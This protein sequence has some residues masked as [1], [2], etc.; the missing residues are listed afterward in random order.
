MYSLNELLTDTVLQG[1][2]DLHLT[3]GVPPMIRISGSL[4]KLG[5]E[6]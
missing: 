5:E 2:S 1:G 6:V 3:V 4:R